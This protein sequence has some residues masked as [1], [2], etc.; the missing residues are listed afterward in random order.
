MRKCGIFNFVVDSFTLLVVP[1]SLVVQEFSL[2][3]TPSSL[4]T[5]Q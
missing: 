4:F 5:F 2:L 3:P 1:P